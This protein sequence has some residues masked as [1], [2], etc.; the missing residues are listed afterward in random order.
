MNQIIPLRARQDTIPRAYVFVCCIHNANQLK[1]KCCGC[2]TIALPTNPCREMEFQ[3]RHWYKGRRGHLGFTGEER[4]DLPASYLIGDHSAWWCELSLAG[5]LAYTCARS[6]C[7][8]RP[9]FLTRQ[10]RQSK[11]CFLL[12]SQRSRPAPFPTLYYPK[13][14]AFLPATF[15]ILAATP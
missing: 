5:S 12:A 7:I 6:H 15:T 1:Q 8:T 14:T 4:H 9:S 2:F 13:R 11:Q 10:N 3:A